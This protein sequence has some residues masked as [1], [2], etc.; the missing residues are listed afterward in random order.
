MQ[1]AN[2]KV[3]KS[4]RRTHAHAD[5][6]G[7]R[8]RRLVVECLEGRALLASTRFAVIGDYGT[9]DA[10][11]A[12]VAAMV[13]SWNPD[14]ILTVG[15]NNYWDG[16]AATID[17]NIGKYYQEFIGDYHGGYGDGAATNRFFPTLGNHD[18]WYPGPESID[19]YLDYFN[20]PGDGFTSSSDNERY[21]DFRWGD[22]HF[23]ALD[24]CYA[25]PDGRRFDS[26]QGR[27]LEGEL[28]RSTARWQIVYF[29]E[30]AYTSGPDSGDTVD[31]QW[32]FDEWG[33]DAVFSGHEHMY[34]RL[35]VD[36]IPYFISGLGGAVPRGLGAIDPFSQFR[37]V[38]GQGAML[39]TVDGSS[40]VSEF[41]SVEAGGTLIDRH[42][43]NPRMFLGARVFYDD[44]AFDS[45]GGDN[46]AIAP[47]KRPLLAGQRAT[48]AN[49]TSY[50]KGLNGLVLE[51]DGA[52][53]PDRLT[54]GDFGFRV[55]NTDDTSGWL[56]A[57]GPASISVVPGGSASEPHRV[58]V[59][60]ADGAIVN[61]WLEVTVKATAGT[62]LEDPTVFYFGS[63]VG[64]SGDST[65]DA[66]VDFADV[67]G[68][69]AVNAAAAVDHPLDYNRDGRT[70]AADAVVALSQF[71]VVAGDLSWDDRLGLRDLLAWR[72]ALGGSHPH[73]LRRGDF[74][75][76]GRLTLSD[77]ALAMAD[78]GQMA[79]AAMIMRRLTLI[80]PQTGAPAADAE[81]AGNTHRSDSPA[82][83][84]KI[85]AR[86]LPSVNPDG[87]VGAA[88]DRATDSA[89]QL[90]TARAVRRRPR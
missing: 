4:A 23:F 72:S 14:F 42:V 6:G 78:Y 28:E 15:D 21:Y 43:V 82:G 61:T 51:F 25:E 63:G 76:D 36:G 86:R 18:W 89:I 9:D 57:P 13:K 87:E 77:L 56:P 71:G 53:A 16:A 62:A 46:A 12:A 84:T 17:Q 54:A 67:W 7:A 68:P 50:D 27:W 88:P 10:N 32:P 65:S 83:H 45:A 64:D 2:S 59:T 33:V 24:S 1:I 3:N 66:M 85:R 74:N 81:L 35:T 5:M 55:G 37:W 41:Y 30:A 26:I 75:A 39:V 90:L 79:D 49:Y 40:M 44:S 60:W 69:T 22:I 8:E 73:N 19:P 52:A 48:F 20:L 80:T 70:S 47:D 34:E 38:D 29:H 11:E 31:M 58:Y